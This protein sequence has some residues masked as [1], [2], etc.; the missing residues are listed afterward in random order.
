MTRAGRLWLAVAPAALVAGAFAAWII[1][2]SQ[3]ID[4]PRLVAVLTLLGSWSF[5]VA[6]VVARIRR[7]LNRTG[8]L[9]IAVGFWWLAGSLVAANDSLVW[10]IGFAISVTAA[11]FLVHLL[12]AYP[13]GRLESPWERGLVAAG[14]ALVVLANVPFLLID[15]QPISRCEEC[16]RSVLLVSEN[17]TAADVL[18]VLVETVAVVFLLAV[19][20][21]LFGRWRRSSA[22]ARRGLTPVLLT[23]CATLM[24][25]AVSVGTMDIWPDVAT[26]A[27][28]A[29]HFAF[30][31]IPFVF[32]SG[33]LKSRLARADISRALAEGLTGGAQ[34]QVRQLLH[35]PTAEVLFSCA[36]PADGYVDAEGRPR[37]AVAEPGRAVTPIERDG[38]PLAAIVHDAALLDEPELLEQLAA[39]VGLEIERDRNLHALQASER[40]NRALVDAMPDNMLRISAD[41]TFLDIQ[42]S[43]DPQARPVEAKVGSS[44]YDY[45]APRDLIDRVMFAGRLALATGQLQTIEWELATEKGLRYQEGRFMPSG[46]DEFFLVV[47]DVTPRKRQETEQAALHRVALAVASE[48]RPEQIFDLVAKEVA[49]VLGAHSVNLVRYDLGEDEAVVVGGWG[50]AGA[51]YPVGTRGAL[52]ETASGAV[53]RA[54]GPLRFELGKG[55]VPPGLVSQMR[56]LGVDS[57]VA[58]PITLEGRPWGAVV[59]VLMAPHSFPPGAEERLG[60]FTRLV[61][62]ALANEQ[63]REDLAASRARLV[64]AG[65]EERRRLERNLHDGAQQRL[66]SLSLSLRLAKA[67][68]GN[69]PQ[70]ANELLEAAGEELGIALEELRELARG[71][72]PAVLTERGLAPALESLADRA[73]LPVELDIPDVRLP[74]PVEGAA[75]Y[76]VSEALANVAKYARASSV[77]VSVAQENGFAIV[78]VADDGVGG[79]DPQQGSGLRGLNDRVEALDGVLIVHSPRGEGT[80]IRAEIPLTERDTDGA[81]PGTAQAYAASRKREASGATG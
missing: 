73:P 2:D 12:V 7:P 47:R 70:A 4:R 45:P 68:L 13:S 40:R 21:T 10:T 1:L 59:A 31:G 53:Y 39:A 33:F 57:L 64:S 75:Y 81:K 9:M 69:D 27:D 23:G 79:A 22:A 42:E 58:A 74:K 34:E 32:L 49:G 78:E 37:E 16:P 26:A 61:S 63:A 20:A 48:G 6:G 76:V 17:Q 65:D 8:W 14:Y 50:E 38:R 44:I 11:G 25:F 3:H 28:W 66:V 30:I 67:K 71:I 43:T 19:V 56:R 29:A 52:R 18:S 62:L 46:D 35:D 60:A 5:I 80:T 24:L 55:D 77:E 36:D 41:G 72:H 51:T 15:P 54:G